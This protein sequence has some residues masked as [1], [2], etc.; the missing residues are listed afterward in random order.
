MSRFTIVRRSA[1]R[2]MPRWASS[3]TMTRSVWPPRIVLL[4]MSQNENSRVL[5]ALC[6][7]LLDLDSFCVFRK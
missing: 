5:V 4:R 2:F 7:S 3:R 1:A 6:T